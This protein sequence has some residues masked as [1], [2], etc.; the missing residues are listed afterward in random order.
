[1]SAAHVSAVTDLF[2]LFKAGGLNQSEF[3]AAKAAVIGSDSIIGGGGTASQQWQG[4]PPRQG[5]EQPPVRE[6]CGG[7]VKKGG[8]FARAFGRSRD[9]D[10]PAKH[11]AVC[12]LSP[13][14]LAGLDEEDL[15]DHTFMYDVGDK[16]EAYFDGEWHTALI[17]GLG[18]MVDADG[19]AVQGA[20][21]HW[22]WRTYDI[23]WTDGTTTEDMPTNCMR[24]RGMHEVGDSVMAIFDDEW[25]PATITSLGRDQYEVE[26]EVEWADGTTSTKV[27]AADINAALHGLA[28]AEALRTAVLA[29]DDDD[30]AGTEPLPPPQHVRDL[31]HG[32]AVLSQ[33]R[34]LPSYRS[35]L[36]IRFFVGCVG[37]TALIRGREVRKKQGPPMVVMSDIVAGTL[38]QH[39]GLEKY[40]RQRITHIDVFAKHCRAPSVSISL[41]NGREVQDAV[42]G[43]LLNQVHTYSMAGRLCSLQLRFAPLEDVDGGAVQGG[44]IGGWNKIRDKDKMNI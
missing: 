38:A 23:E 7:R 17:H 6:D 30:D 14:D 1:M 8:V 20:H 2:I 5:T 25:H 27:P 18:R 29:A 16:V 10:G 32:H 42:N 11:N 13:E 26:Y 31:D 39:L 36:G 35:D 4:L 44:D 21:A 40:L 37:T 22:E 9:P 33:R 12:A 3:T 43:K 15:G 24:P 41:A 34:G 19:H 28:P